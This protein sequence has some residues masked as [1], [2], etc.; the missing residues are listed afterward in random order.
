MFVDAG[1]ATNKDLTSQRWYLITLTDGEGHCNIVPAPS[2]KRVA[3]SVFAAELYAI[4]QG[5]ETISSICLAL[6]GIFGRVVSMKCFTDSKSLFDCLEN[7]NSTTEK[8]LLIGLRILHQAYERR[9]LLKVFWIPTKQNPAD[10]FTKLKTCT[11]LRNLLENNH[12]ELT[13]SAWVNLNTSPLRES[14]QSNIQQ[15]S[16]KRKSR[17]SEYRI[18][19]YSH[20][21]YSVRVSRGIKIGL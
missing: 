19:S 3:R 4:I 12:L 10:S 11:A 2:S 1:F 9:E 6:N 15:Y 17:V 5:F 13:P 21:V 16:Q 14:Y 8:R 7:I 20:H 18:C